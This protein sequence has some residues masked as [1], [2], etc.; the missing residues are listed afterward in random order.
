MSDITPH[1]AALISPILEVIGLEQVFNAGK[2]DEVRAVRDVS[3]HI[4]TGE[5][6]GLVGESG[7]GKTTVGRIVAGLLQPSA[8]MVRYRGEDVN[9]L[10]RNRRTARGFHR[11]VQLVFQDPY[12]SLDARMKVRDIVAEGLDINQLTRTRSERDERV[13]AAL[14]SV[15]LAPELGTR[16]PHEFSGGQRQRIGIAR[17]LIMEPRFVVC[18]EPISALDVSVQA[19]VVNLLVDLKMEHALTYLFIA[20]N[21]AM[22][23]HVSDRIGVMHL[24]QLVEVAPADELYGDPRHPYTRALLS[25]EPVPEPSVERTRIRLEYDEVTSENDDLVEVSPG[26]WVRERTS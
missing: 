26:H 16:Y 12:A 15:G 8:G 10:V 3:F 22:V 19:Q 24:G 11:E 25:A 7:S 6:F 13:A 2:R 23:R 20:H 9:Q 4:A 17:A 1:T 5:T 14:R 21:L 18:D